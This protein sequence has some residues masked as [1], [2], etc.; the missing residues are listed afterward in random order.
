M[1][2]ESIRIEETKAWL[3]KARTDFD[4]ATKLSE[5][6]DV[7]GGVA[8]YLYQQAAEKGLKSI[9]VWHNKAFSRTHDLNILLSQASAYII[10]SSSFQNDAIILTLLATQYRYPGDDDSVNPTQAD[11]DSIVDASR[12]IVQPATN[13]LSVVDDY[14]V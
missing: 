2:D 3:L 11:L 12:R 1:S 7:F 9:L 6:P 14:D 8:A 10:E 4:A 13:A 5:Q